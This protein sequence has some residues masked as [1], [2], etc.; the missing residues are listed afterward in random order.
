MGLQP[1]D[2]LDLFG[3]LRGLS[4]EGEMAAL[5]LNGTYEENPKNWEN[6][7]ALTHANKNTPPIL[8]INSS[9]NRFHAGRDDMIAI[10]NQNKI[11]NEVKTIQNSPH[12]FWFFNPWFE[13]TV[14]YTTEFLATIFK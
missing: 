10:L 13:E 4:E 1:R 11:Y 6:T 3:G 8:F 2:Q 7:S 12:S 9:F 5:W 14:Q